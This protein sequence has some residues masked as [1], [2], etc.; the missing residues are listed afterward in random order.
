MNEKTGR[1][2]FRPG[3]T[4]IRA[5]EPSAGLLQGTETLQEFRVFAEFVQFRDG[6][7][8]GEVLGARGG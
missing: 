5:A 2:C 3:V 7:V 4:V 6:A 8:A 1:I